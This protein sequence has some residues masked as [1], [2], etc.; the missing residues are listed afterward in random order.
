M[1]RVSEIRY[2]GYAVT[3][4]EEERAFYA[5]VWGLEPVPSDDGMRYFKAQGHDEHHVVR[6]RA[7]DTKR[8]DVIAL[9]ADSRADVDALHAKVEAA[10]CQIIHAP[11][12]LTAPGGGYGFR[13]FS[14]D[15][16]PFEISSDVARGPSREMQRWD[17]VPQK[18]SHIVLHSPDHQAMVKFFVDVLGFRVSDWLGDFMC[19]LRCNS[20]HHRIAILPGPACLN[21]VAYDMLTVDDM[22][23]GI[24]R[25]RK[26]GTDIRWGPGRHTAGNNT[27]S[28]FTT[29]SG[30]AVEYTSELEEVDFE[31]HV[32]KVHVPGP[33][34][35]DQWGV[36]VGGPQTMPHPEAD[37]GLFRAAEA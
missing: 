18:I 29:P 27:F 10:G 12:D 5:D 4:I 21:H 19:F 34:I 25:L 11:R 24:S 9:A 14:P 23:R 17:G 8:I 16:L 20:A 31:T 36:G 13:F 3:A 33:Q 35:M 32:D 37:A 15:G 6:L 26:K 28:Y 30:F 22:M 2:V 7:A 1:S